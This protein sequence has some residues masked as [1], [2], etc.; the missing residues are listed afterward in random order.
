MTYPNKK[1]ILACVAALAAVVGGE[2]YISSVSPAPAP[3][4]PA[5]APTITTHV[6]E[7]SEAV[8]W[9][10]SSPHGVGISCLSLRPV[11]FGP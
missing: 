4:A 7:A 8:C 6:Y 11:V 3:T 1:L 10:A 5:Q 2:A 9:V